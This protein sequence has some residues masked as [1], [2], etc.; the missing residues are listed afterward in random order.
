M[1]INYLYPMNVAL[2]Y[3]LLVVLLVLLKN[4]K[5]VVNKLLK[6]KIL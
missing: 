1:S 5:D 2:K 6:T 3:G 4:I